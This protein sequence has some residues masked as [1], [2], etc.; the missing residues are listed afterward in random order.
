MSSFSCWAFYSVFPCHALGSGLKKGLDIQHICSN[1]MNKKGLGYSAYMF[2]HHEEK[3]AWIFS[4]YVYTAWRKKGLDIQHICSYS[5]KKKRL[6]YSAYMFIQHEEERT[7]IFSIYVHT[8]WR[9]K[10]GVSNFSICSIQG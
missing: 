1:S 3:R 10:A 2:I 6:G 7:W 4:I 8:A 9:K 5:M